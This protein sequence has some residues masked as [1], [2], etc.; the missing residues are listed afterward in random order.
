MQLEIH[1]QLFMRHHFQITTCSLLH[2]THLITRTHLIKIIVVMVVITIIIHLQTTIIINNHFRILRDRIIILHIT[3][4]IHNILII[5]DTINILA[6][7][8]YQ[9]L[10]LLQYRQPPLQQQWLHH[11]HLIQIIVDGT[12]ISR[13]ETKYNRIARW[14]LNL[15]R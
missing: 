10:I 11:H 4:M 3:I 12:G 1:R 8:C 6:L 5:M 2:S 7:R 9:V 15:I 14:V 13:F